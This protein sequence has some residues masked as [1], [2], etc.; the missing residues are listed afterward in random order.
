MLHVPFQTGTTILQNKP[1]LSEPRLY[2]L[3]SGP[4]ETVTDEAYGHSFFKASAV[5]F[6]SQFPRNTQ[7]ADNKSYNEAGHS[8]GTSFWLLLNDT[9]NGRSHGLIGMNASSAASNVLAGPW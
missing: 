2:L 9:L 6:C 8:R 1:L 3:Q 4:A 7:L 5:L